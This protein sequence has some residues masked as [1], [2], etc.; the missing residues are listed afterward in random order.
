[1]VQRATR[2]MT[3]RARKGKLGARKKVQP[4][5]RRR[6]SN[7]GRRRMEFQRAARRI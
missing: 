1:M 4:A 2:R 6:I 7:H 3:W 5:R